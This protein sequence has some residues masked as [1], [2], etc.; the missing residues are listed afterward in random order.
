VVEYLHRDP[1]SRR[2]RRNGKSQNWDSKIWSRVT[3]IS[4][5]RRGLDW[6]IGFIAPYTYTFTIRN[7]RQYSAIAILRTSQ[8]TVAHA[9]GFS[10]FTSRIL[11]TDLSHSHCNL[12]S[13]VKSSGHSLIHFLPLFCSW[14]FR[15]LNST[16][17]DYCSTRSRLLCLFITPL[18]GPHGKHPCILKEACSLICYLPIDVLLSLA[19]VLRECVYRAVA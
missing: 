2:R 6:M 15:R 1:A 5:Y 12:K 4:D 13:H 19:C 3:C 17:L 11:A 10:V 18:H 9:L 8:F 16:A 7:Y 14:Q